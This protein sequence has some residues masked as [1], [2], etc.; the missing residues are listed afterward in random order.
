MQSVGMQWLL[1]LGREGV[2]TRTILIAGVLNIALAC[3]LVPVHGAVGMA[4][5]VLCSETFVCLAVLYIAMTD[6]EH[7]MP[8]RRRVE[9]V[10][11][12]L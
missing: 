2:V 9:I 8:F 12:L 3:L 1:P 11:E 7:R 5:A 6:R 10:P 4:W